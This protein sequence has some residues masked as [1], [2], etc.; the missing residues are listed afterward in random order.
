VPGHAVE[1]LELVAEGAGE[2]VGGGVGIAGEKLAPDIGLALRERIVPAAR[3]P[4]EM[5]LRGDEAAGRDAK[6]PRVAAIRRGLPLP[7][8]SGAWSPPAA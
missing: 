3:D 6:E 5:V 8:P 2:P 4:V 7:K 1:R